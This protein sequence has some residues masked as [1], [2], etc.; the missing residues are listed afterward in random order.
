[1]LGTFGVAVALLASQGLSFI[2]GEE[3]LEQLSDSY[4]LKKDSVPRG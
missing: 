4:L 1:M 2:M 3:L